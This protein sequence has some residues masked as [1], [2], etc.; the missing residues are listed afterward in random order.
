V[1]FNVFRHPTLSLNGVPY[2]RPSE[3]ANEENRLLLQIENV[4]K[5]FGVIQANKQINCQIRDGGVHAF[6]GE[7]GAGKSTL[8][9]LL[10][11]HYRPDT[12]C[13]R[14]NDQLLDLRCP[15]DAR[16]V[17]IGMVAQ[18]FSLVPTLTALE[19]ILLGDTRL[20]AFVSRRKAAQEVRQQM[21]K[22]ALEFALDKLTWSMSMVERQKLEIFKLLWRNARILILDEPTSQLSQIEAEDVLKAT[23]QLALNG[24]VVIL[25]THH[26]HEVAEFA[27]HVTVLRRGAVA[28]DFDCS[29]SNAAEIASYMVESSQ[30]TPPASLSNNP[31]AATYLQLRSVSLKSSEKHKAL[32]QVDLDIR[33]GEVLGVAGVTGSGQEEL[34]QILAGILTPDGG[35]LWCEGKRISWMNFR[36]RKSAAWIPQDQSMAY[37]SEGSVTFNAAL[38]DIDEPRSPFINRNDHGARAT[39]LISMFDVMPGNSELRMGNFSGG[40]KQRLIAARELSTPG[41]L[42]VAENPTAGLDGKTS[43]L[44]REHIVAYARAGKGVIWFSPDLE[45]LLSVCNRVAIMF[46]GR[47]VAVEPCADLNARKL[48]MLMGGVHSGRRDLQLGAS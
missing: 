40:N 16:R 44:V 10:A 4:S 15:E 20:G 27:D 39:R 7:N 17:G 24:H 35:E 22:F 26:V 28:A 31:A 8:M 42:L 32:R 9:K 25:V 11:G 43:T 1:R 46:A 23:K 14:L 5:S 38:R 13:L 3:Q 29:K 37:V 12:G 41:S 2:H 18:Q 36:R 33:L 19:N 30:S 48:G 21:E 6:V 45:E 47:V 34:A